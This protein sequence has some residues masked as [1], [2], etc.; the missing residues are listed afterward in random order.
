MR[1]VCN[2]LKLIL[3]NIISYIDFAGLFSI[4]KIAIF[5]FFQ[6]LSNTYAINQ[7]D[8][9][10]LVP[11]ESSNTTTDRAP[12][13]T[14]IVNIAPPNQ[15]GISLNN[16]NSYN[17]KNDNQIINNA[18]GVT[19]DTKLAGQIYG[20]PHFNADGVNPATIIINQDLG[21]ERSSINGTIEIA[22]P[23]KAELV[24]ANGNGFDIKGS[25]FINIPRVT[26]IT[27]GS[28]INP[29]TGN[30]DNFKISNQSNANIVIS[31]DDISS[32]KNLGI[33]LDGASLDIVSR[34]VQIM[35]DIHNKG[36]INIS[37]GNGVYDYQTKNINSDSMAGSLNKPLFGLDSSAVGGMYGG[38]IGIVATENGLGV[39]LRGDLV[40]ADKIDINS[41]ANIEYEKADA[42]NNINI[43]SNNGN[44]IFGRY[45]SPESLEITRSLADINL[46][47]VNGIEFNGSSQANN[48][49]AMGSIFLNSKNN[50]IRNNV[51]IKAEE[52]IT[53]DSVYFEN[54]S[55]LFSLGDIAIKASNL[56]NNQV[57]SVEAIKSIIIDSGNFI[58]SYLIK[59][60]ADATITSNASFTDTS[61]IKTIGNLSITASTGIS[62]KDLYSGGNLSLTNNTNG[63]INHNYQSYSVGDTEII[64]KGGD[65]IFGLKDNSNSGSLYSKGNLSLA[66]SHN[67]ANNSD[68]FS[69][70]K[71]NLAAQN[72]VNNRYL[73][74]IGTGVGANN[75]DL[76]VNLDGNLTNYGSLYANQNI[77][78]NV[79]GTIA[80]D[81]TNN[82]AG[83][84]F[85]LNGDININGKLYN[86]L[87]GNVSKYDFLTLSF[88]KIEDIWNALI[89]QKYIDNNGK[90]SDSFKDLDSFL[91]INILPSFTAY[92]DS[93]YNTL[94]SLSAKIVQSGNSSNSLDQ[95]VRD[96]DSKAGEIYNSLQKNGYLDDN[97][98][99]L[100]KFYDDTK[101]NGAG[102]LVLGDD[103]D[104]IYLKSDI[105]QLLQ[106][107]RNGRIIENIFLPIFEADN[108]M[109]GL[110]INELRNKGYIDVNGNVTSVF[111]LLANADVF[112]LDSQ[113]NSYKEKIYHQ[114]NFTKSINK[115]RVDD[116]N[117]IDYRPTNNINSYETL[118]AKLVSGGYILDGKITDKFT[119]AGNV[120]QVDLV[121]D[122]S[123]LINYKIA[124]EKIFTNKAVGDVIDSLD[125]GL[126]NYL[127]INNIT[128]ANQ[129]YTQL[130]KEGFIDNWG[131]IT[132]K[133]YIDG[134]KSSNSSI[135]NYQSNINESFSLVNKASLNNY[136]FRKITKSLDNSANRLIEELVEAGYLNANGN[137]TD[138]FNFNN[139][140]DFATAF[141]SVAGDGEYGLAKNAIFNTL[142][143]KDNNYIF[144][145]SDFLGEGFNS[146]ILYNE[147][148]ILMDNLIDN[149]YISKNG[150]IKSGFYNLSNNYQNLNLDIRF[151]A[152][153][154]EIG[155]LLQ[156]TSPVEASVKTKDLANI[157][158]NS[159]GNKAEQIFNQ[160]VAGGYI[161]IKGDFSQKLV[162]EIINYSGDDRAKIS[163]LNIGEYSKEYAFGIYQKLKEI[164]QTQ[165]FANADKGMQNGV[166]V[167][168]FASKILNLNGAKITTSLGDIN[169]KAFDFENVAKDM[170]GDKLFDPL[171]PESAI[172]RIVYRGINSAWKNTVLYGY[173]KVT[174]ILDSKESSIKAGNIIKIEANNIL[175]NSSQISAGN[176]VNINTD[177]LNNVRTGFEVVVPYIYQTHWKKCKWSGCKSARYENWYQNKASLK[178]NRPAIISSGNLLN[179]A[180]T[181][182]INLDSP[183]IDYDLAK[184]RPAQ[185]GSNPSK[186]NSSV[187]RIEIPTANNGLFKKASPD[188]DYL[189]ASFYRSNDPN[190]LTGSAYY[191]SRFGFDPNQN[192]IKWLGDPFYEWNAINQQVIAETNKQ[193]QWSELN[194]Q[195]N[196]NQL[197]DNA[198]SQQTS[199]NLIP[200]IKLT[201][202]QVSA[203]KS[204]IIWYQ[205]ETIKLA[206]GK[207]QLVAVPRIY[208]AKN[209]IS[210]IDLSSINLKESTLLANNININAGGNVNNYG[211]ILA[212]ANSKQPAGTSGNLIITSL[213]DFANKSTIKAD[214]SVTLT[215]GR[216][217]NN[218]S[219]LNSIAIAHNGG[220]DIF[221]N[222]A[223]T[224][225]IEAGVIAINAKK[226]FENLAAQ[227]NVNKNNLGN[228]VTSSGNFS[229]TIAGDIN[230]STLEVRNRSEARWGDSKKGGH[231]IIDQTN[232]ISSE[233][234]AIGNISL[235]S[236]GGDIKIMG[237]NLSSGI[238]LNLVAKNNINIATAQDTLYSLIEI[239][240]KGFNNVK[241][242][243]DMEQ[244]IKNLS[245]N[246]R[247]GN[248]INI[249]SGSDTNIVA[250]NLS[251]IN[252]LN[253]LAGRYLDNATNTETIN[254]EAMINILSAK[255]S[256]YK[257]QAVQKTGIDLGLS[258][259]SLTFVQINRNTST[260]VLSA[261]VASK[262]NSLN[263]NI[264]LISQDDLKIIAS[265][266]NAN[267]G[268]VNLISDYGNVDI[269]S[270]YND[271]SKKSSSFHIEENIGFEINS[272]QLA[273]YA[274]FDGNYSPTTTNQKTVVSSNIV[275]SKVNI[276]SGASLS[277]ADSQNN[278][279]KGNIN[280][281]SSNIAST[282]NSIT[283]SSAND[284]NFLTSSDSFEQI[285]SSYDFSAHIKAGMGYNF[286]DVWKSIEGLKDVDPKNAV[287]FIAINS[288]I[289]YLAI[290]G[291][292]YLATYYPLLLNIAEG[293]SL[294]ESFAEN[295]KY[296]NDANK[297]N[298]AGKGGVGS[299]SIA[300]EL[301][302][303][304]QKSGF[305]QSDVVNN[306]IFSNQDIN[307]TSNYSD[308]N[309]HSS[310]LKAENNI[311]LNATKGDINILADTSNSNSFSRSFDETASILLVGKGGGGGIAFSKSKSESKD[312]INS[313]LVANNHFNL[314]SGNNTN[315]ISSNI[316]ANNIN[317][318]TAVD[319][320]LESRQ[321]TSTSK[322]TSFTI[323]GGFASN[324]GG[325]SVNA[326]NSYSK[327]VA[328]RSWVDNQ[329]SILG[330]GSVAINVGQNAN[331]VGSVIANSTN[332][333]IGS[334][335]IDGGNL[336]LNTNT[337]TY[338]NLYD[339]DFAR[340]FGIGA[341]IS[342]RS[343]GLGGGSKG[344]VSLSLNYSMHDFEQITNSIIGG[345]MIKTGTSLK[346]DS[347]NK[348]IS[349]SGGTNYSGDL[350]RNIAES[351]IITKSLTVDPINIKETFE[352]GRNSTENQMKAGDQSTGN[353]TLS[354]DIKQSDS[355]ES[356]IANMGSG[357]V[358][359]I[360]DVLINLAYQINPLRGFS[361]I[362]DGISSDLTNIKT[363]L[364]IET[365]AL[366]VGQDRQLITIDKDG[367]QIGKAFT[368]ED[369][370]ADP[371][372]ASNKLFSNGIMN[373]LNDATRNAK[374]QLGSTDENGKITILYDPSTKEKSV[375]YFTS[376]LGSEKWG[377]RIGG[378]P[379]LLSDLGEVS[380]NYAGANILGG[381]IQTKGQATDEQFIT[382]ITNNAKETGQTITLA[383]HSGGGLRN[384][385]ALLNS[386]PNQYLNSKGE[387]VLKVQFSGTPVNY[388]D[389]LQIGNYVGVGE[390]KK[391]NNSGDSVGNV[392]GA[393]G[394][395]FEGIW[396]GVNVI[397]LFEFFGLKSHHSNYECILSNCNSGQQFSKPITKEN[398][399]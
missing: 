299:A 5:L 24:I 300:V 32:Y 147:N 399:Q 85:S 196:I 190:Q 104:I 253:I 11:N 366:N 84:I 67:V 28:N 361:N 347:N 79:N 351:Q 184:Y 270:A 136:S 372:L 264:N 59:A 302:Y 370:L 230:I 35:G 348:L 29:Q 205:A 122:T 308:I 340:S 125:F 170:V 202:E 97:G 88:D 380:V 244:Q 155:A 386:N 144:K 209:N 188:S 167:K 360:G 362:N 201:E 41:V 23:T 239:H 311:N 346:L 163:R 192:N 324:R 352:F 321:N 343:G 76:T 329:A 271:N 316:L 159:I 152:L 74:A 208:L 286:K 238:D 267:L 279:N 187:W 9:P 229:A 44:I 262:L 358:S 38:L 199:L 215:A 56:F 378:F 73:L 332:G 157:V 233:I 345:G 110:L 210:K 173:D 112:K 227:I 128:N 7:I 51:S 374:M 353:R 93:I 143:E 261:Q 289:N 338:S 47:G 318:L 141:S 391:Q 111:T 54:N 376:L 61:Q 252:N 42:K 287:K 166:E 213:G 275:G 15:A 26:I 16:W 146:K 194:W 2:N 307:L 99:V 295:S 243:Q 165:S 183:I 37:L 19:V 331:L 14:P 309:I 181:N 203:L 237:S 18:K 371:S 90:I 291:S 323:G 62:Y 377:G 259:D 274:G 154:A 158:Q 341:G 135:L 228:G 105:Y 177:N 138:N 232:N 106:D 160:M 294:D 212:T 369:Y 288:A 95:I 268:S 333:Q 179:I 258:N 385:L 235:D 198:Y 322:S 168:S 273:L 101:N 50:L 78:L 249:N 156:K 373:N 231:S 312:Y 241:E 182:N 281:N 263:G 336:T 33:N 131:N 53:I 283:L 342:A 3:R 220:T 206:D 255:D 77:N 392:L 92:K 396:S 355:T 327:T 98:K 217:I 290:G 282:Q 149:N 87:Y 145:D 82:N 350:N 269:L 81:A 72:F 139:A 10:Y 298:N 55:L 151:S 359:N 58:N 178:S 1:R 22:G 297:I 89:D 27:G 328:N 148:Q 315:I 133:F 162:D 225:I 254:N 354:G 113:F 31:G 180:T 218:N 108:N 164:Y 216:N 313:S 107:A 301:V 356:I 335:G 185:E 153:K 330:T 191:K 303:S 103:R 102:G 137:K 34:E 129:L 123:G 39:R 174:S 197:I 306:N 381:L 142:S 100:Q 171:N 219:T 344:S 265:N 384:Y 91:K 285:N 256:N 83:E 68:I 127:P 246:L 64:N 70:G 119:R 121:D 49:Y 60:G 66:S 349:I 116:F 387:S 395:I 223:K 75:S 96:F 195:D 383:G 4:I 126:V 45:S 320:N 357:L 57:G 364:D 172:I 266:I 368:L 379:G 150:D 221:S 397:S 325:D 65:I 226:D 398:Q 304:Q 17:V 21:H 326:N 8:I 234:T 394:N 222:I 292:S 120:I 118:Y 161:N 389:M 48:F 367:N 130:Q 13:G 124:V 334:N 204:D 52:K 339:S 280:I 278:S 247:V 193:R 314:N 393:N 94:S 276:S 240:K 207:T 293:D 296:I 272:R 186:P 115:V 310:N 109:S 114:I 140:D 86:A 200:G 242:G 382:A 319:L 20:N 132:E 175:N 224:A 305:K 36:S 117:S 176:I 260:N 388:F 363:E 134:I 257:Y 211:H 251:S 46:I 317:I 43:V 63:N 365:I 80:N 250:S 71:I 30:I 284:I 69:E 390:V 6:I 189:I 375:K 277:L 25:T 337:F 236:R 248:N 245:S 169:I 214:N 40:S 12:N